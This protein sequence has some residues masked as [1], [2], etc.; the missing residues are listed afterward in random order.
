MILGKLH[1]KPVVVSEHYSIFARKVLAKIDRWQVQFAFTNARRVLPVSAFLQRAIED[2]GI[3]AKF[4]VVPNVVDTSLF[5]P[6]AHPTLRSG[7][8]KLLS[9]GSLGI[10]KGTDDL[11]QALIRLHTWRED[12]H[13]DVIGG[14]PMRSSTGI[15]LP[16]WDLRTR[17]P[18][19]GSSRR[20][21]WLASCSRLI[22]SYY[23]VLSRHSR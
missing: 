2:N 17:S 20:R 13:L 12:W 14:G 10:T 19:T 6:E 9:V 22:S 11:L 23:P 4:M 18:F 8:R 1:R 21:R 5:R 3:Q 7:P 16:N 15:R